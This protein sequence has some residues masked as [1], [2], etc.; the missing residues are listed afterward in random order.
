MKFL[1]DECLALSLVETAVQ[2][3][4]A[5]SAHV[6]RRGMTG[7]TDPQLMRRVL[8]E[9][10]TLLTRNSDDFR[11]RAGSASQR[12]CY[13]DVPLH[14]DL[15]CLNLP[16]RAAES[17]HQLFF[18]AALTTIGADGDLTNEIL[19]VSPSSDTIHV[20]RYGFP[21]GEE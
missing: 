5:A 4:Y 12:P 21:P 1:I 2:A 9:D 10:W 14:A 11:P 15:V 19:E 16:D 20:E 8:E 7:F 18:R 13:L 17:K 6:S 3:G